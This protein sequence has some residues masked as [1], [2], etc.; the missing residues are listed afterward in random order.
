VIFCPII[1]ID[2]QVVEQGGGNVIVVKWRMNGV[3]RP[4]PFQPKMPEVVGRTTYYFDDDML[5]YKHFE[6][7]D[8]SAVEAFY[9]TDWF[10]NVGG[11]HHNY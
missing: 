9:K 3:L 7:W 6:E 10:N 1:L 4:L 2:C 8:I 5:V 11:A